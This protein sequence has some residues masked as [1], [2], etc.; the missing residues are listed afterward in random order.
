VATGPA[1]G[2]TAGATAFPFGGAWS[3]FRAGRGAA[4]DFPTAGCGWGATSGFTGAA[5]AAALATGASAEL[6]CAG[7]WF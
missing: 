6:G 4:I 2:S 3:G 1:G 7:R 5:M